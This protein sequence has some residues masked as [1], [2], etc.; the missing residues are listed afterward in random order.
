MDMDYS[1]LPIPDST[2]NALQTCKIKT[3]ILPKNSAPFSLESFYTHQPLFPEN[4]RR[5][6]L[7]TYELSG[8]YLYYD[9]WM[10]QR[11]P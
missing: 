1:H 10:C 8:S 7:E 9:V 5:M 2:F 6:F 3:W 11:K 4:F